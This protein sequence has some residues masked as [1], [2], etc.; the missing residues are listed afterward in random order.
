MSNPTTDD[1]HFGRYGGSNAF[2]VSIMILTYDV[3]TFGHIVQY[4]HT[5]TNTVIDI[6]LGAFVQ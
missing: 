6:G 1:Q 2:S 3:E 4:Q 5:A